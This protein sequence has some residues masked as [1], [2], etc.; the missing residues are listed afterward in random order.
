MGVGHEAQFAQGGQRS[1][2]R[3]AMN[4]WCRPFCLHGDVVSRQVI[5][6]PAQNLEHSSARSCDS[7]AAVAERCDCFGDIA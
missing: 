1:I 3:G 6:R 4:A 7:F 2:D 5:R